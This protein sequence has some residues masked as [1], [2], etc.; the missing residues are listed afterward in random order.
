MQL[1]TKR[2]AT[3]FP[4]TAMKNLEDLH[5]ERRNSISKKGLLKDLLK[6][7]IKNSSTIF[8]MKISR[9]VM[10]LLL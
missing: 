2:K 9:S 8:P 6:P 10:S 1:V 4:M 3:L 5:L 7:L